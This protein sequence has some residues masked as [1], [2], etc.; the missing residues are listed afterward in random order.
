[1]RAEL[2]RLVPAISAALRRRAWW[3]RRDGAADPHRT[4]A[5]FRRAARGRR[6]RDRARTRRHGARARGRRWLVVGRRG[7]SRRPVVVNA[8][9]AW[10][11]RIAA[12]VGDDIPLGTRPR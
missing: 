3:L 12:M 1:M 6:R 7:A 10:A 4:L 2:R 8:A 11:G 9:G 5:A